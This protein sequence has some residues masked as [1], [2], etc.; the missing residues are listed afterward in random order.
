MIFYKF[1]RRFPG[2]PPR[3]EAHFYTLCLI[4]QTGAL[5]PDYPRKKVR[6]TGQNR[7]VDRVIL[8]QINIWASLS[9][10]PFCSASFGA[11][12][13]EAGSLGQQKVSL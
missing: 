3:G 11:N 12:S 7:V 13:K 6:R 4:V 8:E 10:L 2:V 5:A 1:L 9:V